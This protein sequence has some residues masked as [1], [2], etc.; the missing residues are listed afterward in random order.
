M[1]TVEDGRNFLADAA[2]L[3]VP[4]GVLKAKLI[5]FEPKLPDWKVSAISD[6]GVGNEKKMA[7]LFDTIF[8]SKR[9]TFGHCC[10]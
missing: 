4:L 2:I 7:L 1:A 3:T 9:G 10:A 8:W 6:L 5:E